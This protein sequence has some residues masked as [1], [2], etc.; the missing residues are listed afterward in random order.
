[1]KSKKINLSIKHLP[2]TG[3][4]KVVY[5]ADGKYSE[6][7]SYYGCDE[8]DAVQTRNRM[9]TEAVEQGHEVNWKEPIDP[10][11]CRQFACVDEDCKNIFTIKKFYYT[12]S[13]Q[14]NDGNKVA[15]SV[16]SFCCSDAIET[17]YPA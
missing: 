15:W 11:Y 10:Y 4:W 9:I 12:R 6:T 17:S 2:E 8:Q 5:L 13:S 1:M 14:E 7:K 16:C 3:E